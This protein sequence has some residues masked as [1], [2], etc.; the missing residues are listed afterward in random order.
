MKWFRLNSRKE[1]STRQNGSHSER[2]NPKSSGS[3]ATRGD[4]SSGHSGSRRRRRHSHSPSLPKDIGNRSY[5]A[6]PQRNFYPPN[7]VRPAVKAVNPYPGYFHNIT[8]AQSD[9]EEG[10]VDEKG[11]AEELHRNQYLFF[12]PKKPMVVK[13]APYSLESGFDSCNVKQQNGHKAGHFWDNRNRH[14]APAVQ[15][16]PVSAN[17]RAN[18]NWGFQHR[19]PISVTSFRKVRLRQG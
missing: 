10:W 1:S 13:N 15:Y 12:R 8:R 17:Q 2:G 3:R 9:Y 4:G 19:P 14:L 6:P 16:V 11:Y 18:W 5:Y 7:V